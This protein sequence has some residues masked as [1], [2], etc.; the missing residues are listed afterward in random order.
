MRD[1]MF[2]QRSLG[3]MER[4]ISQIVKRYWEK[5]KLQGRVANKYMTR[6]SSK[7]KIKH[8]LRN[9]MDYGFVVDF[10]VDYP[11]R[12]KTDINEIGFMANESKNLCN[13]FKRRVEQIIQQAKYTSTTD[14]EFLP[15][16][17]MFSFR[18]T[19]LF[20]WKNPSETMDDK[21]LRE[22]IRRMVRM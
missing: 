17:G 16:N 11:Q 13:L 12:N 15:I 21:E 10:D 3:K 2:F 18:F 1:I 20:N 4:D 6:L 7:P 14:R 5:H 22:T 9:T 19:L 8:Y